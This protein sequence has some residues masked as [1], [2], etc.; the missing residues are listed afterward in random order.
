MLPDS[1]FHHAAD[2]LLV[3]HVAFV[4]FVVSGLILILLGKLRRWNWVRNPWFRFA[5][6]AAIGIVVLGSWVGLVCPLTS[7]EMALR[8]HAGDAVY[9]GS[10]IAHWLDRLLYYQAPEWVFTV[11]YTLFGALVVA[12]WFWVRPRR[13]GK[14]KENNQGHQG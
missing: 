14:T 7:L 2:I 13:L 1:W 6:L 4:T 5:H 11:C 12:S 10:F 8:Q 3:I 9:P